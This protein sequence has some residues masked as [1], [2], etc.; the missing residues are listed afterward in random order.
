M[1]QGSQI[2]SGGYSPSA[3]SVDPSF[4]ILKDLA[5]DLSS[6]QVSFPTF[7]NATLKI[8]RALDDPNV[9]ADRMARIISS[10]PLLAAKL[11]QVA[12]SVALGVPGM[13]VAD[14]KG[15]IL[16]VGYSNVHSIASAV[17]MAQLVVAKE[18]KPFLKRAEAVWRHSLEVA[19]IAY[20]LARKLTRINPDEALFAGLVHDVGRFYL[21]SKAPHYPELTADPVALEAVLDEWHAP[22]GHAVLSTFGLSD[23]V[24]QAVAEHESTSYPASPKT[25]SDVIILANML[26]KGPNPLD[27]HN[28]TFRPAAVEDS[29]DLHELLEASAETLHSLVAAFRG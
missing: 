10:E 26:S 11:V 28:S 13:P 18:M 15:A 21:L 6:G 8:R 23:A 22:I 4:R 3:G 5:R 12:N 16:R 17:A 20:V 2:Q 19:A 9:D 27:R 24:L 7:I 1:H 25:M 14:V 29:K